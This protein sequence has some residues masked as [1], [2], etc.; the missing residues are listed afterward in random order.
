MWDFCWLQFFYMLGH[1]KCVNR[2]F[3]KLLVKKYADQIWNTQDNH[4]LNMR[5]LYFVLQ[6][7]KINI[8]EYKWLK[9]REYVVHY[10]K[11]RTKLHLLYFVQVYTLEGITKQLTSMSV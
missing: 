10:V 11:Q 7:L 5:P 9:V 8:I 3:F 4:A 6:F 1:F 2:L